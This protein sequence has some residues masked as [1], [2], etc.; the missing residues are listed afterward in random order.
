MK[1]NKVVHNEDNLSSNGLFNITHVE[2][3]AL[4]KINHYFSI[5]RVTLPTDTLYDGEILHLADKL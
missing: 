3:T 2:D 5:M 1:E 4:Q